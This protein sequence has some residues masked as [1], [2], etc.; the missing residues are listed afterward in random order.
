MEQTGPRRQQVDPPRASF[1]LSKP[2]LYQLLSML[3]TSASAPAAK[4][5][6]RNIKRY[7]VASSYC[8]VRKP[9]KNHA[10]DTCLKNKGS[11]H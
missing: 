8:Q 6:Q 3:H 1:L 10:I 5:T 7:I 4:Q 11:M 2:F 9:S